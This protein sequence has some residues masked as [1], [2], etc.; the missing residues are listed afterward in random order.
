MKLI[1]M[2]LILFFL[3]G[4][5]GDDKNDENH[6]EDK[7]V[8]REGILENL[9]ITNLYESGFPWESR[10]ETIG[11]LKSWDVD[12]QGLI[13]VKTN[14]VAIAEEAM[15][16]IEEK[17]GRIVFDRESI[18]NVPDGEISR[19]LIVSLGTALG[20]N[21]VDENSCG[22]VSGYKDSTAYPPG[23]YD[24]SGKINAVLYVHISSSK[25]TASQE[26][27]VHEFGHALGMG[28]HFEGFGIGPAINGNFWNVLLN[29][30]NNNVGEEQD[31]L[32]INKY[33]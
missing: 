20:P 12:S 10:P 14:D 6:S 3:A 25:C 16:D 17:L 28:P 1:G 5:G 15:D 33:E 19:G 27:A 22:H 11:R 7:I 24:K 8:G 26:V 18:A 30:F 4:C 23:F 2:A 13:P 21:G 29:I 31:L 32:T 9:K